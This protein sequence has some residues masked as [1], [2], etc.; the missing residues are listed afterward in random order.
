MGV[1]RPVVVWVSVENELERL[2]THDGNGPGPGW[3]EVGEGKEERAVKAVVGGGGNGRKPAV[4][5][6]SWGGK[7][8][9]AGGRSSSSIVE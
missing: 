6:V 7:G 5:L 4:C 2:S 9:W 8:D 3:V 1:V